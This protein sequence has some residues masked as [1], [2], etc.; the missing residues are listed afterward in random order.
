MPVLDRPPASPPAPEAGIGLL[1]RLHS[2]DVTVGCRVARADVVARAVAS[3]THAN[4]PLVAVT[5]EANG[6]W[7]CRFRAPGDVGDGQLDGLVARLRQAGL[8]VLRV[9]R[10]G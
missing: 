7:R 9:E 3:V 2:A 4:L 8:P 6:R 1:P 10:P 5:G